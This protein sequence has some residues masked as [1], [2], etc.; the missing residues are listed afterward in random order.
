MQTGAVNYKGPTDGNGYMV[1]AGNVR[2][3][4]GQQIDYING[5][6]RKTAFLKIG[7]SAVRLVH[8]RTRSSCMWIRP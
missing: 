3:P 8:Q 5:L 7:L 6:E 4:V 1:V 2:M